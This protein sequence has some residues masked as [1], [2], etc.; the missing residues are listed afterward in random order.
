MCYSNV[1]FNQILIIQTVVCICVG[2]FLNCVTSAN[3]QLHFFNLVF[4]CYDD[5]A[6]INFI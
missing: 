5:Y 6:S 4:C 1:V 3:Y 2:I